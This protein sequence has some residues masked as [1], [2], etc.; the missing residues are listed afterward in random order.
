MEKAQTKN[1]KGRSK[2]Q[3][4]PISQQTT[5]ATTPGARAPHFASSDNVCYR[6]SSGKNLLGQISGFDINSEVARRYA[7]IERTAWS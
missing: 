5:Y 7:P 4:A 1:K 3:N 2:Q 6:V